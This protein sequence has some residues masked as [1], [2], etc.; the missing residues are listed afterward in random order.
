M[1]EL[2]EIEEA[3]MIFENALINFKNHLKDGGFKE[4]DIKLLAFQTSNKLTKLNNNI[5]EDINTLYKI[6]N[7]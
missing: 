4:D 2:D 6:K 3:Y 1:K 5:T 7:L